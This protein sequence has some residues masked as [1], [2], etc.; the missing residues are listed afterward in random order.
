MACKGRRCRRLALF[1][2]LPF[3]SSYRG[4]QQLNWPLLD[5]KREFQLLLSFLCILFKILFNG[6][7]D[8]PGQRNILLVRKMAEGDIFLLRQTYGYS[9]LFK[10]LFHE[11]LFRMIIIL[12]NTA[13]LRLKVHHFAA[14]VKLIL[15]ITKKIR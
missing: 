14:F 9:V 10:F 3:D 1:I 6:L 13:P 11:S 8:D 7:S 4:N 2:A 12:M 15:S 5:I